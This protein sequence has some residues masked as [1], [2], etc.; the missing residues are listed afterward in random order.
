LQADEAGETQLKQEIAAKK[1]ELRDVTEVSLPDTVDEL[2]NFLP[3]IL[4]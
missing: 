1:Q 2:K 4:K 3:N